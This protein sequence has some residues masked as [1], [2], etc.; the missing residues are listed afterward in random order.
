MNNSNTDY[1]S[2]WG[3]HY[4]WL[5]QLPCDNNIHFANLKWSR[6]CSSPNTQ[7]PRMLNTPCK[8][9]Y[10]NTFSSSTTITTST[11]SHVATIG[12][13][14]PTVISVSSKNSQEEERETIRKKPQHM[15]FDIEWSVTPFS[16][17]NGSV[18]RSEMHIQGRYC[19]SCFVLFVSFV[20]ITLI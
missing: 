2:N 7:L 12:D 1:N 13:S 6:S 8:A 5:D 19:R 10:P 17:A 20:L 15:P 11:T 4:R 16:P 9:V 18:R 14:Q 3:E